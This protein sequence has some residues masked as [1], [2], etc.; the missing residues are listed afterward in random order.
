MYQKDLQERPGVER[1]SD[2]GHRRSRQQRLHPRARLLDLG[3]PSASS[4]CRSIVADRAPETGAYGRLRA[5]RPADRR[6]RLEAL[7]WAQATASTARSC[8]RRDALAR[9]DL[10]P[11]GPRAA[12]PAM[13]VRSFLGL[14]LAVAGVVCGGR[15]AHL[16]PRALPPAL[17]SRP[18]N[19]R[20]RSGVGCWSH[21]PR[22]FPADRDHPRRRH[23]APGAR[24]RRDRRRQ[25]EE[26]SLEGDLAARRRLSGRRPV[27]Q[28]RRRARD[29]SSRG[30]PTTSPACCATARSCAISAASTR[31]SRCI[32]AP[33][34]LYP[35]SVSL[36]YQLAADYRERGDVEVAREIEWRIVRDFPGFGL[37]VLR[38]RRGAALSAREFGTAG[39]LHERIA[40]L[41]NESGDSA[42]LARETSLAQ[43]LDYQRGV[44]LLEQ[45]RSAEAAAHLPAICWRASRGS[46]RRAS[47]WA[48]P[49]SS[50]TARRSAIAA[51]RTRLSGD[52][53][54]GLPAADRGP[55]HR[56][57]RADAR[58]SRRCAR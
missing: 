10:G 42:A 50:R 7:P 56:A 55:L 23:A 19:C 18:G 12:R 13:R 33:P 54:P 16:Q 57:G 25:R 11:Y 31:R 4:C 35:R 37:E 8:S 29:P 20:S 24:R 21:L 51:W 36:L 58:R 34:R 32:A 30:G 46:F 52:R 2:R 40:Q 39:E 14:L 28:G 48:R 6:A 41:L 15:A 53:Q 49:S 27:G 38:G 1:Q 9:P 45:D 44:R 22:R 43:G 5:L 17:P 3:Q 26:E 47:C